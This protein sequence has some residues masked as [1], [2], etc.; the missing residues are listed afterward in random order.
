MM[1]SLESSLAELLVRYSLEASPGQRIGM[2]AVGGPSPLAEAL[3]WAIR[4][5]GSIPVDAL[6]PP[7]AADLDSLAVLENVALATDFGSMSSAL[8]Q[9]LVE[10]VRKG[11]V[12]WVVSLT[13]T[14]AFRDAFACACFLDRPAPAAEWQRQEK[15]QARI[16]ARLGGG[17][18]LRILAPPATDLTLSVAGRKWVNSAGR[19]NMPDGEIFT[20]P[21]ADSV[22]GTASLTLPGGGR[23]QLSF[24]A[25]RIVQCRADVPGFDFAARFGFDADKARITEVGLGCNPAIAAPCGHPLVDEKR[26]GTFHLGIGSDCGYSHA[27]RSSAAGKGQAGSDL[28]SAA[29]WDL[30]GDLHPDG[31]VCLDGRPL[32][33][34]GRTG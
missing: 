7:S 15:V 17:R 9:S 6:D 11:S 4:R 33:A 31:A 30:V 3:D 34:D 8:P 22:T 14:D 26:L 18:R 21:V 2:L 1:P 25:G 32:I 28:C 13:P 24:D 10:R 27:A 29:H 12:R 16:I 5:A 20:A 23:A 19:G